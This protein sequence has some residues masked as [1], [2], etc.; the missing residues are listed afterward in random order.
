MTRYHARI[1]AVG[2]EADMRRLCQTMLA[3]AGWD[4]DPSGGLDE[5]AGAVRRFAAEEGGPDC[6]FLYEMMTRRAYGDAEEDTCRFDVRQDA[7][8]LWTAL[9]TY[10][11]ASPF[12]P[13]DWLRLHGQAGRVPMLVLRASDD[14]DRAKGL[15]VLSGGHL[16]EEWSRMEECW[17]WLATRYGEDDQEEALRQ[18]RR[19][20]RLL[21]DEEED[22]TVP[23]LLRR[24]ADMLQRMRSNVADPDMLRERLALA[25]RERDYQ[26]LFALQCLAA[27]SALWE[28]GQTDHWLQCLNDLMERFSA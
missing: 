1:A 10:E 15:L 4:G 22:L 27:Q 2:S 25:A 21:E 7:S 8:G 28:L 14:F 20:A 6:G 13:E 11:S 12:Q 3:N 16:Q 26:T 19:L 24:C 9:F 23:T 5:L 17:L 18:L